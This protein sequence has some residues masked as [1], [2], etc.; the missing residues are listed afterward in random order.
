MS[1]LSLKFALFLAAFL[2]VYYLVPKTWMKQGV[3]LMGNLIFC[4]GAGVSAMAVVL[5]TTFVSYMAAILIER[6]YTDYEKVK[7]DLP[8]K[9][10]IETFNAY[11][12]KCR[13]Y[14]YAALAVAIVIF[15]YVKVGRYLGW[16]VRGFAG[17]VFGKSV[18]VPIGISYYTFML[19][20]YV[21]DVYWDKTKAQHNYLKFLMCVTYFPHII[22][23]PFSRLDKLGEQFDHLPKFEYRRFCFGMQLTLWGLFQKLVIAEGLYM[24]ISTVSASVESCAGLELVIALVFNVLYNFADFSG[25]MDIVRGISQVIGVELEENFRQPFFSKSISEFW[26][27]WHITLGAWMRDYIFLPVS[28]SKHFRKKGQK[29]AQKNRVAGI[30]FNAGIPLTLAWLFSGAWHGT[31]I[32]FLIWGMYYMT[33]QLLAQILE[34]TFETL[35]RWLHIDRRSHGWSVWQSIRTFGLCCI[36]ASLTF[37]ESV[38]GCVTLWKQL[39]SELRPWVLFDGSL[40]KYGLEQRKFWMVMF[41]VTVLMAVEALKER[42]AHIRETIAAKPLV[43]RWCAY[44]ALIFAILIFGFYGPGYN[45]ADFIYAGF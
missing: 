9:E 16:Q 15:T 36:G 43:L 40:Y 17:F 1:Y 38:S 6:K 42:G 7:A 26:R 31:G 29:I 3:I 2:I 35:C 37:N 33:L 5:S 39:L 13:V 8:L 30:L 11:K 45:A 23:G 10:R 12:K 28:R 25:C 20:G 4:W 44:Y 19:V 41:C 34:P 22:S 32:H 27:R 14:L 21:L 24:F 18:V